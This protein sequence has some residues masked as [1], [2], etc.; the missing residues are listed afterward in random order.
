MNNSIESEAAKN[1]RAIIATRSRRLIIWCGAGLSL[2]AGLPSWSSLQRRLEKNLQDKLQSLD[3]VSI[4]NREARLK[5]IRQ[6]RNP[7]I[8]FHRL[9]NELGSTSFRE[10]VRS[11]MSPAAS[12]AVPDAYKELWRL[13]PAGVINLNI[14]RLAT[15]AFSES[16]SEALIEFKAR[17]ISSHLHVLSGPRAFVCNIHGVEEDFDSWVFTQPSLRDLMSKSEYQ[18]FISSV[19]TTSCVLFLGI[20]ADDIAVGGHLER[21]SKKRISLPAHYWITDRRDTLTDSWAESNQV[22]VIRYNPENNHAQLLTILQGLASSVPQEEEDVDPIIP[23]AI[24]AKS[25]PI[26]PTSL[27]SKEPE[28]IR[29]LLNK[30]ALSI[31]SS[32]SADPLNEYSSFS[33]KYDKAIHMAWYTSTE[34]NENTFL[35]LKLEKEI[36]SGA[37]GVVFRATDELG[38]IFAVKL[39]HAE[40]RKKKELLN[41]FRRGVR[42]MKI[43]SERNIPGV[44]RVRSASEIPAAIVMDW[45]DGSTLNEIVR[46]GTLRDWRKILEIGFQLTSIIEQTHN[47][48]ERVLHRDIRPANIMIDGY[49][50]DDELKVTVLDFD[51]SWHRG[52]VEKSVVFGSALAGYLAPEQVERRHNVSTQHASVDSYGIGMT[53]FFM[54][55]GRDPAPGEHAHKNWDREL[56]I[57]AGTPARPA[58]KSAPNRISRLIKNA[59]HDRQERRWDLSQIRS[60]IERVMAAVDSMSTVESAEL[61]AEEIAA[62]SELSGYVWNDEKL[63]VEEDLGTGRVVRVHGDESRRVVTLELNRVSS[64]SDNRVRLG[65]AI[66]RAK[67]QSV[68]ALKAG[69]WDVAYNVGQGALSVTGS[70]SVEHARQHINELSGAV[71]KALEK[72]TF[73]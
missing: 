38:S 8:A 53:L 39:L 24:A 6:E 59:T 15:R 26:S 5:S 49:W 50:E 43:I 68:A 56:S 65:D 63:M 7:W 10:G 4:A 11:A 67:D 34:E 30:E 42:S 16:R 41:A 21:F 28:E 62:R 27:L 29:A 51:L 3:D 32:P 47:L 20:T 69:G 46:S 1:L 25:E 61:L 33:I 19:L 37:F 64:E 36:A 58:W 2:P 57:A 12:S 45:V 44:A 35:G 55:A 13:R 72:L 66:N 70:I 23:S 40:I 18:T 54:I 52:S 31:L 17:E 73:A 14:D 48:P 22:Q 71:R 60:E 9:Q